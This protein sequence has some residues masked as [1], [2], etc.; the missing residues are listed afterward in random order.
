VRREGYNPWDYYN[1]NGEL[2]EALD[3][4]HNGYFSPYDA[5]AFKPLFDMLTSGGDH[6]LLL[7]DYA[8]YVSCHERV[9][10]LY[11]QP[12]NWARKAVLNVAGMGKFSSDRTIGE[13]AS[14]IW[15]A[16]PVKVDFNPRDE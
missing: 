14:R 12:N 7:A 3:M 4:I 9:S 5:D 2:K 10:D 11:L 6:Y 15:K 1:N 8:S 13:Y 16:E